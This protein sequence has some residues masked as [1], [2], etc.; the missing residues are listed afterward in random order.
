MA[1]QDGRRPHEAQP[2]PILTIPSRTRAHHQGLPELKESLG[3]AS[4]RR[5]IKAPLVSSQW[6]TRTGESKVSERHLLKNPYKHNKCHFCS[7]GEELVL[8]F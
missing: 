1:K 6:S 5:K 3:P 4:T 7:F 8:S 2:E